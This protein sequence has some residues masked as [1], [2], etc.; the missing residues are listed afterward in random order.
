MKNKFS[1]SKTQTLV[2]LLALAAA[3]VLPARAGV[4]DILSLITD[5]TG[6]IKDGIG[7]ALTGIRSIQNAEKQL[8]QEVLWPVAAIDQAKAEVSRI[9]S[10]FGSLAQQIHSLSVNS[11][12]LTH[13]QN[14]ES[15]LRGEQTGSLGRIGSAYANVYQ[16]APSAN[17]ASPAA[18]NLV[19]AD[20]AFASGALKTAVVSDQA[21]ERMLNAADA[22]ERQAAGAA[23]GSAPIL[24]AQ[25]LSADLESQAFLQRMLAAE[26]REEAARLAHS[27]AILKQSGA[28]ANGLTNGIQ[29]VLGKQ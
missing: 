23:P 19:D 25:A 21:S 12:T 3:L 10:Q 24:S 11:A 8:Q 16:P 5:I 20:D 14:L 17:T 7:M 1:F 18:R 22:I 4:G 15:L 28:A 9:R 29:R 2:L 27:N 6:T 13:P 26:L